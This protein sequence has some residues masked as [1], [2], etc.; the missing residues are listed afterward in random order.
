RFSIKEDSWELSLPKSQTR[1]TNHLQLGLLKETSDFFV[2]MEITENEDVYTFSYL[3]DPKMKKWKDLEGLGI[4]EKLRLLSNIARLQKYIS[5]RK[6]FFLHPDNLVF[7][8]NLMPL[9]VYR[10]VRNLVPPYEMDEEQF[11]K[12]FKC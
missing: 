10:G 8:D 6:T 4:N 12:Q 1:I 7:N 11:F 9:I 3:V 5:T 2:P